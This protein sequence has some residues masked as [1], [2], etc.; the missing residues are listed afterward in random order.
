MKRL[1]SE[2]LW[3]QPR[4]SLFHEGNILGKKLSKFPKG[5]EED[6]TMRK[7]LLTLNVRKSGQRNGH[8]SKERLGQ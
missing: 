8:K 3:S 7:W 5:N 1:R 2:E 6:S 4:G